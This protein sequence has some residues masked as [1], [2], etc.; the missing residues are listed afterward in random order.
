MWCMLACFLL[1]GRG[2]LTTGR[3]TPVCLRFVCL[4]SLPSDIVPMH[5]GFLHS[6]DRL[7]VPYG[8]ELPALKYELYL[9]GASQACRTAHSSAC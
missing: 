8:M 9:V 1:C 3:L 2:V 6:P 4:V 5:G 7:W